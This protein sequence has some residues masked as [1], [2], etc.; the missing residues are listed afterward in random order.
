VNSTKGGGNN[1]LMKKN[2]RQMH[3][4][5]LDILGSTLKA[6]VQSNIIEMF[7]HTYYSNFLGGKY[8]INFLTIYATLANSPQKQTN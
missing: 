8:P 4:D 6:H 2:E 1:S 3:G 5:E 7:S